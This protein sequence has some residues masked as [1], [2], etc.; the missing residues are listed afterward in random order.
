MYPSGGTGSIDNSKRQDYLLDNIF[1]YTAPLSK[2]NHKLSV[3]LIQSSEYKKRR[4]LNLD[5]SDFTVDRD[6]NMIGDAVV[7]DHAR[8][9]T[10]EVVFSFIGRVNYSFKERYLF[11]ASIRR[12]APPSSASTTN[13]PL[14]LPPLLRGESPRR[15]S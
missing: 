9:N 4:G 11:S 15:I 5:G 10:K 14:S 12:T 8:I 3:N 7:T 2:T 6:W 1:T 13:G